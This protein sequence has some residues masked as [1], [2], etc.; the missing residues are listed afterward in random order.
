MRLFLFTREASPRE[1]V[2]FFER[3]RLLPRTTPFFY[4]P[5]RSHR[6]TYCSRFAPHNRHPF[7][8]SQFYHAARNYITRARPFPTPDIFKVSGGASP[9]SRDGQ[10]CA[11]VVA[12]AARADSG[13]LQAWMQSP[14][15]TNPSQCLSM[16]RS[17]RSPVQLPLRPRRSAVARSSGRQAWLAIP[18]VRRAGGKPALLLRPAASRL[19]HCRCWPPLIAMLAPV[20]KAA[21]R[22]HR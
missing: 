8:L 10:G 3:R 7:T 1:R 19:F 6:F 18:V 5:R 9:T 22:E 12:D 11:E 20:T 2:V 16:S 4:M 21:S 13:R 17:S 15:Q 14:A